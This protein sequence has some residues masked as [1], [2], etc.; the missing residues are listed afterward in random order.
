MR[1]DELNQDKLIFSLVDWID[2][3]DFTEDANGA[4]D[5]FYTRL[6]SPYRS[7]N[8]PIFNV[9]ELVNVKNYDKEIVNALLPFLCA[10][11]EVGSN[12]INVNAIRKN[13]PEILVMLFGENLSLSS[14]SNV[15]A[16]RPLSG[17]KDKEELLSHPELADLPLSNSALDNIKF[18]SNFYRLTTKVDN[19]Q[20]PFVLD[21]YL[22]ILETGKVKVFMRSQGVF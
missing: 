6:A 7:A 18:K 15:L 12:Q 5:D 13:K 16:D 1:F 4:E 8:Q 19:F 21:S 17:F 3:N 10:L 20:Y 9:N 11:P 22:Q 14:A 2:S